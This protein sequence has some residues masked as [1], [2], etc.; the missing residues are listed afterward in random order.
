MVESLRNNLRSFAL[1]A[2][3]SRRQTYRLRNLGLRLRATLELLDTLPNRR[4]PLAAAVAGPALRTVAEARAFANLPPH[5]RRAKGLKPGEL[6]VETLS[7]FDHLTHLKHQDF[8]AS[9][10]F[11]QKSYPRG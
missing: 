6:L 10:D 9:Q 8:R 2:R 5:G 11:E 4:M 7:I 1:P 3:L